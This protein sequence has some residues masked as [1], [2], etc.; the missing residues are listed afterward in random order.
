MRERARVFDL[1]GLAEGM[2]VLSSLPPDTIVDFHF[3]ARAGDAARAFAH[4]PAPERK[5]DDLPVGVMA[6]RAGISV[7]Q[8]RDECR[9]GRVPDAYKRAGRKWY[10]PETGFAQYLAAVRADGAAQEPPQDA[11]RVR[12]GRAAPRGPRRGSR[13]RLDGWRNER[14]ETP[15]RQATTGK[16]RP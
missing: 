8:M 1:S 6:E 13:P 12:A 9:L 4:P 14:G 11:P 7:S 16:G 3:S 10:A 15:T 5:T 2:A